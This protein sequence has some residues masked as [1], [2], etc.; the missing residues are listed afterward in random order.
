MPAQKI[1]KGIGKADT[2]IIE[3][4]VPTPKKRERTMTDFKPKQGK[5]RKSVPEGYIRS[6][7]TYGRKVHANQCPGQT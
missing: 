1:D 5:I 6:A 2:T 4:A 3:E 7:K